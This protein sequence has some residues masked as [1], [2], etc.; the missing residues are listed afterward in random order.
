[1]DNKGIIDG[2]WKGEMK[3]MARHMSP[4]EKFITEGNEKAVE[5]AKEGAM[6]DAESTVQARASTIERE[7]ERDGV[8]RLT[9]CGQLSLFGGGTERL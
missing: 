8:C 7:R 1:M 9:V 5:L 6:W 2:L 4:F 3:C